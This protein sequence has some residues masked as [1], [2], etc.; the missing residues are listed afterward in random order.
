MFEVIRT[1]RVVVIATRAEV[2]RARLLINCFMRA[3][4]GMG[5][6][7]GTP[8]PGVDPHVEAFVRRR[9]SRR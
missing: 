6:D 9:A 2:G 3:I 7:D 4:C 1:G 8:L 5:P